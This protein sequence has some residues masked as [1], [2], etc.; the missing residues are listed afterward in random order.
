[1]SSRVRCVLPV[2]ILGVMVAASHRAGA[3][4]ATYTETTTSSGTL[5]TIAFTNAFVTIIQTA[6][7]ANVVLADPVYGL[8][9]VAN[10]TATVLITGGGLPTSIRATITDATESLV[11]QSEG[12]AGI[13]MSAAPSYLILAKIDR[14]TLSNY[15]LQSSIVSLG[16]SQ[17]GFSIPVATDLGTLTFTY[18]TFRNTTF[19]AVVSV[20]EPCSLALCGIAG[21]VGLAVARARPGC[22][23]ARA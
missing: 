11:I 2:L 9:R 6:D 15:D 1:M 21:L 20:P 19:Q 18:V 23:A 12:L 5:G 8:Y 10:A 14:A 16:G 13:A 4:F 22:G 3:A 17:N 7:T